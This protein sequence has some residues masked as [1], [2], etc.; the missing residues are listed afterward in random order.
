[1]KLAYITYTFITFVVNLSAVFC[2]GAF[3]YTFVKTDLE[4][5]LY[6]LLHIVAHSAIVYIQ[7]AAC[8][9]QNKIKTDIF[10]H[11]SAIYAA[12][13]KKDHFRY[14]VAANTKS[15]WVWSF[16]FKFA[17]FGYLVN[18]VS[19]CAFPAILCWKRGQGFDVK[20]LYHP[21]KVLLPWKQSTLFGYLAEVFYGTFLCEVFIVA[22]GS[23]LCLF[24]SMSWHHEAF[25][26]IFRHST[27]K[28]ELIRDEKHA[29]DIVC[30]LVRF[31]IVVKE[32]FLES[33]NVYSSF[34]LIQLICSMISMTCVVFQLDLQLKRFDFSVGLLVSCGLVG[35]ANLFLF[36]YFGKLATQSF[37][38]MSD[39]L[40]ESDWPELSVRLQKYF[41]I[42]VGN[43]QKSIF[44]NGFGV[45]VLNLETFTNVS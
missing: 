13:E 16:F 43:T 36:C 20:Y 41:I 24:M 29:N 44:Y 10:D 6:A 35:V 1:M 27:R 5:C 38:G 17:V 45:A 11:L 37:E 3:I 14:L 12:N 40:Y 18:N 9:L 39:A 22:T 4:L 42:M 15:E 34:I 32:W 28:L 2:A 33:A 21:F 25:L 7:I 26:Y 23:V 19:M 31:H 30:N 8:L